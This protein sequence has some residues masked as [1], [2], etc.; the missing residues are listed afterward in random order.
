MAY[1]RNR[2]LKG[3][4]E[5]IE[6]LQKPHEYKLHEYKIS[7]TYYIEIFLLLGDAEMTII[8][9]SVTRPLGWPHTYIAYDVLYIIIVCMPIFSTT[10]G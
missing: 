1:R 6:V 10:L 5:N 3:S 9:F 7:V 8:R 2:T 4:K